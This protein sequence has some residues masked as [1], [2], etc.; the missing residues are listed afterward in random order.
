MIKITDGDTHFYLNQNHFRRFEQLA[1]EAFAQAP[2]LELCEFILSLPAVTPDGP[3]SDPDSPR[4]V[5]FL[6]SPARSVKLTFER[7]GHWTVT[8]GG[9][10]G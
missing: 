10:H 6:L 1:R 8:V 3:F 5:A 4:D 9:P 2:E 7:D